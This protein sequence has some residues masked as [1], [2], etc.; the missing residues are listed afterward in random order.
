VYVTGTVDGV[1]GGQAL[2]RLDYA[3]RSKTD[4]VLARL[5]AIGLAADR[6]V[7]DRA[8]TQCVTLPQPKVRRIRQAQRTDGALAA[9]AVGLATIL[10]LL[11]SAALSRRL[12]EIDTALRSELAQVREDEALRAAYDG[13]AAR[14]TAVAKRRTKDVAASELLAALAGNL[15][16]VVT[17]HA[18]EI[19]GGKGRLE[20]SGGDP[21][22]VLEVLRGIPIVDHPSIESVRASHPAGATFQI[23]RKRP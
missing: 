11:Q 19:A 7:L 17:V 21:D 8:S 15:P 4:P 2:I 20:F 16:D 1:E 9:A 23:A 12:D 10:C 18:I 6:L 13:W 14:R 5:A 3:P 22:D